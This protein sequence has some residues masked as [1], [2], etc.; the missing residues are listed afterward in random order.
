[1]SRAILEIT[2]GMAI[3]LNPQLAFDGTAGTYMM[4]DQNRQTVA[5]FK[6]IDEEAYAPHNPRGYIGQF[7]QTSFRSGV[8]SGEGVIREVA[9]YLMDHSH[10][11]SVPPT[12][13]CEVMHPSFHYSP[14]EMDS[15][16]F[17]TTKQYSN[18]ISSLVDPSSS[19][20]SESTSFTQ[21][22]DSPT[23]VRIGVKYGSLQYFVKSDDLCSNFSSDLFSIDQVHKIG[24]LDLRIMN[25]D[26]N[27]GNLLVIKNQVQTSK[28]VNYE[29]ELIPIDH[30]LS[31]PDN[32]E[33]YSYD[34]CWMDWDQA[35]MPFSEKSL[36]FIEKLDVLKDIKMLDDT[37]KFRK[38]CLRNIR[39]TGTLLKLGA[40]NSLTLHQI[41]T[42]LCREDDFEDDPEP[43]LLE[44]IVKKAED[45]AQNIR[46][47]KRTD[48]KLNL[49]SV[50][51]FKK[52]KRPRKSSVKKTPIF[53]LTKNQ[54]SQE[55]PLV[56]D[57]GE[58]SKILTPIPVNQKM[59]SEEQ[60]LDG[61]ISSES[62]SSK[63]SP[64]EAKFNSIKEEF[65]AFEDP[66]P[67][68]LPKIEELDALK[69]PPAMSKGLS[70]VYTFENSGFDLKNIGKRSSHKGRERAQ[71]END[72]EFTFE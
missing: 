10:F 27:D 50:E 13:F 66:K 7:G 58:F 21:G 1:M 54:G 28:K 12:I 55:N 72:T 49:D 24:I 46:R 63:A 25:L 33:I 38:I 52:R 56:S 45:M 11:S 39:I 53:D 4:R 5:I 65:A 3:G 44:K 71:S 70:Q 2:K 69:L 29:Y 31:I 14:Q 6:P 57:F 64:F 8:L 23:N 32:L 26:R 67:E 9:S 60:K 68:D 20:N 61:L 15:S 36:K 62:E 43:S 37:F 22:K 19:A 59:N 40:Q 51:E 34:I 17:G 42:M 18:A 47:I 30:S 48:K 16:D 35:L 41:G